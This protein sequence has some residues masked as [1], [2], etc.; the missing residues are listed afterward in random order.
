VNRLVEVVRKDGKIDLVVHS[1]NVA[2]LT[3]AEAAVMEVFPAGG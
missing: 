3:P 1:G 2:D